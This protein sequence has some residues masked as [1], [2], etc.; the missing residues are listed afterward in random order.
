MSSVTSWIFPVEAGHVTMFARSIGDPNP[1]FEPPSPELPITAVPP[2]FAIAAAQFQPGYPMRPASDQRWFGSA[3]TPGTTRR[4]LGN[5]E[6]AG[7]SKGTGFHA[8]EH[9]EYLAPVRAGQRLSVRSDWGATWHKDG[10]RGGRLTFVE[11]ITEFRDEEG[12]LVIR[13]RSVY[14]RTERTVGDEES[15]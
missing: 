9:F 8:E 14:V 10:S 3:S 15:R 12:T 6:D 5:D 7:A 2:T 13:E 1:A 4:V 11:K